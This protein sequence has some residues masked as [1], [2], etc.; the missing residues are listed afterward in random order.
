MRSGTKQKKKNKMCGFRDS[1]CEELD[2][3]REKVHN[4]MNGAGIYSEILNNSSER[5][6]V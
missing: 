2:N 5:I 3:D 6:Q 4:W 1:G